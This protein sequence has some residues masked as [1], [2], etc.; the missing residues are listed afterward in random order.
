M[1]FKVVIQKIVI[2]KHRPKESDRRARRRVVV[3]EAGSADAAKK[4]V[5]ADLEMMG[6]D[7]TGEIV[8]VE[9]PLPFVVLCA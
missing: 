1:I 5:R 4:K 8:A 3:V 6:P 7:S 2:D 9:G